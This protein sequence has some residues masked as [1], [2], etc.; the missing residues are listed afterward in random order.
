MV[1]FFSTTSIRLSRKT[2]HFQLVL[3]CNIYFDW[4][5]TLKPEP[6]GI[7]DFSY[8]QQIQTEPL[9]NLINLKWFT[10]FI[11]L[12]CSLLADVT[13]KTLTGSVYW[14]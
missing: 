9:M 8:C 12:N 10:K 6:G 4:T 1:L 7:L 5:K 13:E 14:M 2:K 3:T 11:I